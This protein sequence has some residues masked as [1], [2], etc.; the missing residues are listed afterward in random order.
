MRRWGQRAWPAAPER[1]RRKCLPQTLAPSRKQARWG[2]PVLRRRANLK[3]TSLL[4]ISLAARW[5]HQ[6]G[7]A[8]MIRARQAKARSHVVP[9][10]RCECQ[11]RWCGSNR[12][13]HDSVQ[14]Y[15]HEDHGQWAEN[16]RELRNCAVRGERLRHT[17]IHGLD[18][19]QRQIRSRLLYGRANGR[20]NGSRIAG[21]SHHNTCGARVTDGIEERNVEAP[22]RFSRTL[23]C[24]ESATTPMTTKSDGPNA[25]FTM[26]RLPIGFTS[27]K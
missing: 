21:G 16:S 8:S 19:D 11:S 9:P 6:Q 24:L 10:A 5:R 14:S 13:G 4:R 26:M 27:P 12:I 20:D 7:P 3:S 25:V 15:A 2:Q 23:P 18:F 22:L 1:S 17:L